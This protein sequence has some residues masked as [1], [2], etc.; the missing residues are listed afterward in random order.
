MNR[1][2]WWTRVQGGCKELDTTEQ[3]STVSMNAHT[4]SYSHINF[5][6]PF[7]SK[8]QPNAPVNS[9]FFS[10]SFLKT[11]NFEKLDSQA[12]IQLMVCCVICI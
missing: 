5:S 10:V 6:E 11:G 3:L 7:K 12:I 8:L 4:F 2:A 1:G 9:K